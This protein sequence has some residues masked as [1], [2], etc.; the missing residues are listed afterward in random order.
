MALSGCT[1]NCQEIKTEGRQGY[2]VM[3]GCTVNCR[4]IKT[5]GQCT[6]W[7]SLLTGHT[8]VVGARFRFDKTT[9]GDH[10]AGVKTD[11][12]QSHLVHPPAINS[13]HLLYILKVTEL[14]IQIL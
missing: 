7:Q 1:V 2:M 8:Q 10:M 3:S 12:S 9:S 11:C 14:F 6:E 5:E 13:S 4:E